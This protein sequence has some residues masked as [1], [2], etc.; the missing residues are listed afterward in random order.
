MVPFYPNYLSLYASLFLLDYA[1]NQFIFSSCRDVITLCLAL[2]ENIIRDEDI[3]Q[4]FSQTSNSRFVFNK[5]RIP[6]VIYPLIVYR[7][8]DRKTLSEE[9]YYIGKNMEYS[10]EEINS[11]LV[12]AILIHLIWGREIKMGKITPQITKYLETYKEEEIKP[13]EVVDMLVEKKS[14]LR[15][16]EAVLTETVDGS[17]LAVYQSIYNFLCL[18]NNV[19][20]GIMRS[21]HFQKQKEE[22]IALSSI[23]LGMFNG[24]KAINKRCWF[25]RNNR[26]KLMEMSQKLVDKWRGKMQ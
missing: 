15:E 12:W 19:E 26:D 3:F 23:I 25:F 11:W 13:L 7:Y 10:A 4:L 22:T 6:I 17:E 21:T 1:C 8:G 24:W 5:S 9:L 18:P 2:A 14:T 16:A 20:K